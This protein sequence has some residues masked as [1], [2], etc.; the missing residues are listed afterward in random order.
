[1]RSRLSSCPDPSASAPL[2]VILSQLSSAP[3]DGTKKWEQALS[4]TISPQ[5][6]LI[7]EFVGSEK[8]PAVYGFNR[9]LGQ[10]DNY[11]QVSTEDQMNLLRAHLIGHETE[12]SA[13]MFSL[14]RLSKIQQLSLGGTGISDT[15]YSALLDYQ[16]NG[17]VPGAWTA[18]YGSGDVV[19]GSWFTKEI[20]EKT[21]AQLHQGDMISLI[22]GN[23]VS[24]AFGIKALTDFLRLA[25]RFVTVYLEHSIFRTDQYSLAATSPEIRETIHQLHQ[26][27]YPSGRS[28]SPRVQLPVSL[29]DPVPALSAILASIAS[30]V[31]AL[32]KR[33]SYPSGNP[34]FVFGQGDDENTVENVSQSSFLDFE[35][36]TALT[37]ALQS[38]QLMNGISQ[39]IIA[40]VSAQ[41]YDNADP[42]TVKVQNPKVSTAMLLQAGLSAHMLPAVF[43]GNES[44]GVEDLWDLSLLVGNQLSETVADS[45]PLLD[46]VWSTAEKPESSSE[47]AEEILYRLVV[48]EADED[49]RKAMSRLRF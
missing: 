16:D 45:D 18:S 31:A 14:L 23:Y 1:M 26:R 15:S 4:E 48:P 47:T 35:L 29:R 37:N 33:L 25:G 12:I 11:E 36:T 42:S 49:A 43:T 6:Q 32:N 21:G 7:E 13:D 30:M 22:S 17:P 19:I 2:G 41:S 40:H 3:G 46:L 44:G 27:C 28:A 8:S 20:L 10:M 24:T 38:V 5:R 9:L 39:R 34:M